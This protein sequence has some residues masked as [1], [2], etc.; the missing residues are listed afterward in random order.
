MRLPAFILFFVAATNL[1]FAQV[2]NSFGAAANSNGRTFLFGGY[3]QSGMHS[4]LHEVE[5][6]GSVIR[7]ITPS[8]IFSKRSFVPAI[9]TET[10][11][12]WLFGGYQVNPPSNVVGDVWSFHPSGGFTLAAVDP[13]WEKRE[14]QA[15]VYHDGWIYLYGGVSYFA[16]ERSTTAGPANPSHLRTFRDVW[17]S[18]NGFD[19]ELLTDSPPWAARRSMGYASFGGYMWVF[20]GVTDETAT[21]HNDI[22]RSVDGAAWEKMPDAPWSARAVT[23]PIL[24]FDGALWLV[25][26]DELK[27]PAGSNWHSSRISAGV[28]DVWKSTD[29][30]N[31]TLMPPAPFSARTGAYVFEL[32]CG[33]TSKIAVLAGYDDV[34]AGGVRSR[35]WFNDLWVSDDGMTWSQ[36]EYQYI[37]K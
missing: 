22:W 31:W 14:A 30:V 29:G 7:D 18:G 6:C 21:V 35:N 33:E 13:Q 24:H 27:A 4:S 15:A 36:A 23:N 19:W 8:Y 10:G 37:P 9:V 11:R 5:S 32:T 28:N 17:K 25:G 16:P 34:M 26:G 20:G 1:S 3:S 12:A 2:P